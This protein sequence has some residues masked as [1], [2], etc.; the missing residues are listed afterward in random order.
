MSQPRYI[1]GK[2]LAAPTQTQHP[3][4]AVARTAFAIIVALASMA[5]LVYG[6]ATQHDPAAATGWAATGLAIASAITRV[7]ALPVVNDFLTRF[8]PFLAAKP[9]SGQPE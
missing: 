6:A 2:A 7:L 1:L 4:R 3:W 5:P 9:A 8:L